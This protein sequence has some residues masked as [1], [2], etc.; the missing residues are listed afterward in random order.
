M[1]LCLCGCHS[2]VSESDTLQNDITTYLQGKQATVGISVLDDSCNIVSYNDTV[3]MPTLS[4]FKFPVALTVLHQM[5]IRHT[6]VDTVLHISPSEMKPGTYSPLRDRYPDQPFAISMDSL[7]YYS[8]VQSD[9]NACDILLTYAGGPE[10]VNKYIRSLDIKDINTAVS[11]DEM[12]HDRTTVYKNNAT[13]VAISQLMRTF[14]TRQLFDKEYH[15]CLYN[16]L[17]QT[18]TGTN[19]LRAGLPENV[20]LGHKTGSSDRNSDGMKIADN[21]AGFVIL[22]DGRRYYITVFVI[23]S[24][25]SD[26]VNARIIADISQKVYKHVASRQGK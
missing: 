3:S 19:K 26:S 20:T 16:L 7:L 8:I 4:V 22:P 13:P 10:A 1:L 14:L 17:I 6:P 2:K 9:N 11:E 24:M 25:E 18:A 15:E 23:H 21:D 12:H 5:D